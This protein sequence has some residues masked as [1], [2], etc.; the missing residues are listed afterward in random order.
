MIPLLLACHAPVEAPPPPILTPAPLSGDWYLTDWMRDRRLVMD[1]CNADLSHLVLTDK[2]GRAEAAARRIQS[3]YI[4]RIAMITG[5]GTSWR[6]GLS[7]N[8][9]WTFSLLGDGR[10]LRLEGSVPELAGPW[11]RKEDLDAYELVR[12]PMVE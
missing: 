1:P 3:V 11:V 5:G 10:L 6:Y 12:V 4:A 2:K 9:A 8:T 7:D